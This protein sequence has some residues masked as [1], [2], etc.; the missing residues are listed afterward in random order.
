MPTKTNTSTPPQAAVNHQEDT[1]QSQQQTPKAKERQSMPE[2]Q[3]GKAVTVSPEQSLPNND[4]IISI[5][6]KINELHGDWLLVTRK[7]KISHNS[8]Y[9][10]SKAVKPLTNRFH[11][12][13]NQSSKNK[14]VPQNHTSRP[15]LL[16]QTRAIQTPKENKRR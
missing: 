1:I 7:K 2:S 5:D 13:I 11:A 8:N 4:E 10:S 14:H 9:S 6:G 16:E 12:L 3:N 15:Y